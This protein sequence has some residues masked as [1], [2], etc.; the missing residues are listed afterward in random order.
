MKCE[1]YVST[2]N[3]GQCANADKWCCPQQPNCNILRLFQVGVTGIGTILGI[4]GKSVQ[5]VLTKA[6]ERFKLGPEGVV[7]IYPPN[8]REKVYHFNNVGVPVGFCFGGYYP[9]PIAELSHAMAMA[10]WAPQGGHEPV[11]IRINGSLVK[12]ALR[13]GNS[14][15]VEGKCYCHFLDFFRDVLDGEKWELVD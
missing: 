6:L 10:P 1:S 9:L 4:Y 7:S 14:V 3:T 13:D 5:E 11:T 12:A 2:P 15:A 8:E